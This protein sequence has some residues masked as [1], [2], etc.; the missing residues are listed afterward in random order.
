MDIERLVRRETCRLKS[1]KQLCCHVFSHNSQFNGLKE[2]DG[3]G[4]FHKTHGRGLLGDIPQ[5]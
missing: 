3:D 2:I 1:N 5:N 4:T